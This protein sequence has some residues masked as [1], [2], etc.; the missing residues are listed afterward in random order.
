VRV[1]RGTAL[2]QVCRAYREAALVYERAFAT[3]DVPRIED[4]FSRMQ[5]IARAFDEGADW[6]R[7]QMRARAMR[8]Q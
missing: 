2:R 4:A 7:T 1:S 8:S 5:E 6:A 3:G